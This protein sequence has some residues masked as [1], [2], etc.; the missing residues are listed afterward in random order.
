MARNPDGPAQIFGVR[1]DTLGEK[2][3]KLLD[4]MD[5]EI[6]DTMTN[7]R[8]LRAF[9]ET[10]G[11]MPQYSAGNCALISKQMPNKSAVASL[12][13][14]N[15]FGRKI[16]EGAR[17]IAI[18][19]PIPR[20]EVATLT[21]EKEARIRE[22]LKKSGASTLRIDAAVRRAA[23]MVNLA[24]IVG[25]VYD[26][27]QTT[28]DRS[29]DAIPEVPILQG[30]DASA[31]FEH[32]KQYC[33][34]LR[35]SFSQSSDIRQQYNS[36]TAKGFTDTDRRLIWVDPTLPINQQV[37]TLIHEIVHIKIDDQPQLRSRGA[38][39]IVAEGAAFAIA[40]HYGFDTRS[41]SFPYAARWG[42]TEKLEF[43]RVLNTVQFKIEEII[44]EAG[45]LTLTKQVAVDV[46]AMTMT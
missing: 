8:E 14:W 39:E 16:K 13:G 29:F 46:V 26:V 23:A 25:H 32:M 20:R 12:T 19:R 24:F 44:K 17:G 38:Q 1:D 40:H 43:R 30:N 18:L 27:S 41:Y 42:A 11:E 10:L 33:H 22:S 15:K 5:S 4:V 21:P 2:I 31:L 35:V 36:G 7:L 28:G 45:E 34:K 3:G 37:K 9:L 6:K